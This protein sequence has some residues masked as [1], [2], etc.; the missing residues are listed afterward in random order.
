[1]PWKDSLGPKFTGYE[2]WSVWNWSGLESIKLPENRKNVVCMSP[3][4]QR[5]YP[6][7]SLDPYTLLED[8]GQENGDQYKHLP[9]FSDAYKEMFVPPTTSTSTSTTTPNN[10]TGPFSSTTWDG[11]LTDDPISDIFKDNSEESHLDSGE[12]DGE[13]SIFH[14][15]FKQ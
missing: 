8:I 1:M 12:G 5:N 10:Q 7:C 3:Y 15:L 4:D 14:E 13:M 2:F 11:Y 9:F 6:E